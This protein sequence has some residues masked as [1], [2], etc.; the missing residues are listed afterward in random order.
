L[1]LI[2]YSMISAGRERRTRV[3]IVSW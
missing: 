2:I 1:L 3:T